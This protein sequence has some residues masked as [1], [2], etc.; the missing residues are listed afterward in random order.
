MNKLAAKILI[1][2]REKK[3]ITQTEAANRLSKALN[4][5]Y[6]LR[7]YQKI[8]MGLFPVHKKSIVMKLEEIFGIKLYSLIYEQNYEQNTPASKKDEGYVQMKAEDRINELMRDKEI[9]QKSIQL[10]LN[11]LLEG[12]RDIKAMLRTNQQNIDDLLAD[13]GRE[14]EAVRMS[15]GKRNAANL[16]LALKM[17]TSDLEDTSSRL[18]ST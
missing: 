14:L 11:A 6:S 9:L 5:G 3:G 10:S 13:N 15:T 18:K 12:Q 17:D 7:Q 8:E 2:A 1:E 4:Q 16:G